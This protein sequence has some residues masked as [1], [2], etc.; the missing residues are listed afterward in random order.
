MKNLKYG[1]DFEMQSYLTNCQT[2][3]KQKITLF[4]YRTRMEIFGEN[5]RNGKETVICPLCFKHPDNQESSFDCSVIRTAIQV[6]GNINDIFKDDIDIETIH[7]ISNIS[8][9]RRNEL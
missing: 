3:I 8:E 1:E 4:K 9:Y 5:F 2:S 6:S 7:T